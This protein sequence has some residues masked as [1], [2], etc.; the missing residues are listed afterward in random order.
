MTSET[1]MLLVTLPA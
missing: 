1:D